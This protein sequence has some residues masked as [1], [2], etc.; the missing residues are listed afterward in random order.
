MGQAAEVDVEVRV[1]R[2]ES[3]LTHIRS[4][5][6]AI[7][8]DIREM[9]GELRDLRGEIRD[10]KESLTSR[11]VSLRGEDLKTRVWMVCLTGA[12]LGV[13]ARGFHWI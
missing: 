13:M 8:I 7:K 11:I 4:D 3:D 2:L 5:I 1:A 9:R 10:V 12:M 6:D